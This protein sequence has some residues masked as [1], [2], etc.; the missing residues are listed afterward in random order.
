M[1]GLTASQSAFL[2]AQSAGA[3]TYRAAEAAR[4]APELARQAALVAEQAR[5]D[6]AALERARALDAIALAKWDARQERAALAYA[7]RVTAA[8]IAFQQRQVQRAAPELARQ[9]LRAANEIDRQARASAAEVQRQDALDAAALAFDQSRFASVR[10]QL[11]TAARI[12]DRVGLASAEGAGFAGAPRDVNVIAPTATPWEGSAYGTSLPLPDGFKPVQA[13]YRGAVLDY[14]SYFGQG[15]G[16]L[17]GPRGVAPVRLRVLHPVQGVRAPRE[18]R[19]PRPPRPSRVPR[20]FL[21]RT[22]II[23]L[24]R[25]P[26]PT[27]PRRPPRLARPRRTPRPPRM[28]RDKKSYI[29]KRGVCRQQRGGPKY[30]CWNTGVCFSFLYDWLLGGTV[31]CVYVRVYDCDGCQKRGCTSYG[32]PVLN[33]FLSLLPEKWAV[34]NALPNEA[35]V[36]KNRKARTRQRRTYSAPIFTY[37]IAAPPQAALPCNIP[38]CCACSNPTCTGQCDGSPYTCDPCHHSHS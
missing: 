6:A 20:Y 33:A 26:R 36:N 35:E 37:A 29:D 4:A 13:E 27:R 9:A 3:I 22:R 18:P 34:H 31:G 17:R 10:G 8:G 28:P 16:F 11:A 21:A 38:S 30:G 19:E 2:T 7:A 23:R 24:P 32:V 14:R 25:R 12:T 1:A 5:L 15:V